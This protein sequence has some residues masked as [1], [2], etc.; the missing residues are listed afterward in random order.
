MPPDNAATFFLRLCIDGPLL[1]IGLM[2]VLDPA[3]LAKL[4]EAL[5]DGLH[6]FGQRLNGVQWQAP[7]PESGSVHFSPTGRNAVRF[8]RLGGH[9][10]RLSEPDLV[11][12]LHFFTVVATPLLALA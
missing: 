7:V 3:S 5:V 4:L 6:T 8:G 11:L 2:M 1:Y 10:R 12:S 9:R